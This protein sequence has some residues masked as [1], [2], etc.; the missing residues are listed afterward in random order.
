MVEKFFHPK[1]HTG[2]HKNDNI[3]T[4]RKKALRAHKG[5]LLAAAR[6]LQ[7][8]AN[9]TVDTSTAREAALDARYFYRMNRKQKKS[10]N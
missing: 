1:V 3:W 10:R 7:A 5:D 4:R 8:L 9:V 2:W 6:A